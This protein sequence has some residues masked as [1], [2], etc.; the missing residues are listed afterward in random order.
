MSKQGTST[1]FGGFAFWIGITL[2]FLMFQGE[3]DLCDAIVH[4][5]MGEQAVVNHEQRE[6]LR[7]EA[8]RAAEGAEADG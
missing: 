8:L 3:P 2:L 1:D 6:Q 5:L 7:L 4:R